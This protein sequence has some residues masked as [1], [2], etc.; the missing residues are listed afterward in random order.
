MGGFSNWPNFNTLLC[1]FWGA[2][3]EFSSAGCAPF[4]GAS[5]FVF[6]TNP[7]YY[8]DT[9]LSIYP[10]F[11][12]LPTALSGCGTV[13]GSNVV[14]VPSVD[15]LQYGQFVQC[16][17]VLP[18]GSVIN[19]IGSG[20]VTLSTQALSTAVTATLQVYE[21]PPIPTAVIQLFLNLATAS[22]VQA[23]WQDAWPIAVAWYAAHY[24][25]LF[26]KSDASQVMSVVET[27]VH[28]E[29]PVGAVP[30]TVYT[31]ST[32]PPG[33][34]LQALT[35]NGL[36]QAPGMAYTLDG[37]TIT[38]A[39]A[40]SSG[41]A[42]YATWPVQTETFGTVPPTGAAIAA[43][44]L[45]GGIQVSKSV[46]DVSVSYQPIAILEQFGQWNLTVYG[47]QLAQMARV[48]GAG[49]SVIW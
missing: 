36:F 30:G 6:G 20:T 7:P 28:G 23:R 46:G 29:A 45:A 19:G 40:T 42:L 41:D 14:T 24:L 32:A 47:Q 25:T 5:N 43:Q 13:A 8:L 1:T 44:G 9:L 38:L 18:S 34:A 21:Q 37:V 12:G 17:G 26:A 10:K 15:G 16:G 11:F 48:I 49:P 39:A 35:V 33:N 31:L 22:L 2:G 3:Q 27:A 4:L